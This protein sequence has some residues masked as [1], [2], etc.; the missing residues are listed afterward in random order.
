MEIDIVIRNATPAE[1][2]KI[3][4][5]TGDK[6][7][8]NIQNLIGA[9]WT[10][11][12]KDS[13]R[14]CKDRNE[15]L[16]AYQKAFPDSTRSR[17]AIHRKFNHMRENEQEIPTTP[18]RKDPEI[19]AQIE[20]GKTKVKFFEEIAKELDIAAPKRESKYQIP[21]SQR[22]QK[23]EY[24]DAR[25]LCI[26]TGKTYPEAMKELEKKATLIV[27]ETPLV[28]TMD[29]IPPSQ[30]VNGMIARQIKPDRGLQLP[31]NVTV[32]ARRA[33]LIECIYQGKKHTID[34]ACLALVK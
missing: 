1:A 2:K 26:R 10:D 8:G 17:H 20:N 32:T 30:C 3:F 6:R 29:K 18:S 31:G 16:A 11:P 22:L 24:V 28:I 15:A 9:A 7:V 4:A 5:I 12:E 19:M 21:F 27:A 34:A 23:K 25:N 33:G 14:H 13:I